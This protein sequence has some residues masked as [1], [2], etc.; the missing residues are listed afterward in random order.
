MPSAA[1]LNRLWK[2]TKKSRKQPEE[3]GRSRVPAAPEQHR[4]DFPRRLINAVISKCNAKSRQETIDR[5]AIERDRYRRNHQETETPERRCKMR[6]GTAGL[7]T[8]ILRIPK[9]EQCHVSGRN[10]IG[11]SQSH[12][13]RQCRK[14]YPAPAQR[15]V[16][17]VLKEFTLQERVMGDIVV[18]LAVVSLLWGTRYKSRFARE[19]G[20]AKIISDAEKPRP[21][22]PV[23]VA[24]IEEL[25]RPASARASE[26]QPKLRRSVALI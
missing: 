17:H 2:M 12:D 1:S 25:P 6:F 20:S 24:Y 9:P 10:E 5:H 13:V 26:A 18:K 21:V 3:P 23:V 19:G 4:I 14:Q 22:T 15:G 11:S 8:T 7:T 16:I